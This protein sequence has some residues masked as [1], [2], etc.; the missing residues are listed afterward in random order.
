L[1]LGIEYL[2]NVV[3]VTYYRT[4]RIT[5]DKVGDCVL[6][7]IECGY[8][9]IDCAKLYNNEQEIGIHAFNR[10]WAKYSIS[11]NNN[12]SCNNRDESNR[13]VKRQ[14]VHVTSKLWNSDHV[15]VRQ[16]C[17]NTLHNLQLEYLDNYL[18]HWPTAFTVR[19]Y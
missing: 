17:K 13:T 3:V 4:W 10:L 8:R 14:D 15:D 2:C 19:F 1:V 7:A 12:L 9:K 18:M 6:Y 5:Q 16:A 11:F